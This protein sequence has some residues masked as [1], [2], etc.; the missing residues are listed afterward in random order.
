MR[1][2]SLTLVVSMFLRN[3]LLCN[4]FVKKV[5]IRS[6]KRKSSS[7]ILHERLPANEA[8]LDT[9]LLANS[10]DLVISHLKA[11]RSN[12]NLLEDVS[13]IATLR[14]ERVS[15]IVEGDA[16][17]STRKT[18]SQQIG[19]LMKEG[20]GDEVV[21]LKELVEEASQKSSALD[22]ELVGIDAEI[23]SLFSVLPNLLDDR[24]KLYDVRVRTRL[25]VRV[26][27]Q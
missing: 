9:V 12:P 10:P 22:L 27:D 16:A 5:S 1:S 23:N 26:S 20:K 6:L 3:A 7:F 8:T 24:Y 18:L 21:K 19:Q 2:L 13:K 25:R 17:K 15:K 11:R 4:S 14:A